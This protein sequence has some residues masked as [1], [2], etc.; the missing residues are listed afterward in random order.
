M[1]VVLLISLFFFFLMIRRPPRST[2]FPYTTLFRSQ[3]QVLAAHRNVLGKAGETA[4]RLGA[5]GVEEVKDVETVL[6]RDLVAYA[7]HDAVVVRGQS[8]LEVEVLH[9][10]RQ[11]RQRDVFEQAQGSRVE[12]RGNHVAGKRLA[13]TEERIRLRIVNRRDRSGER[14]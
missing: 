10:S 5:R 14:A 6:G 1:R 4:H 2:L 11:V 12:R 7:G 3:T 13:R 8:V 9:A